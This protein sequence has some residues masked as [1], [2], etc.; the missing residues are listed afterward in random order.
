ML[1][2]LEEPADVG[3]YAFPA[4]VTI[5]TA[6]LPDGEKIAEILVSEYGAVEVH[7]TPE[8]KVKKAVSKTKADDE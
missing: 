8:K 7:A 1:L 6:A 3:A 2:Q 5:D 4:G